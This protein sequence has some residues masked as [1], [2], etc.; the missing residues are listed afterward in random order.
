MYKFII[1]IL[2]LALACLSMHGEQNKYEDLL[3]KCSDWESDRI[4]TLADSLYLKGN[5]SEEEALVLYM[6]YAQRKTEDTS[7]DEIGNRVRAN[8]RAGNIHYGKGN[9]SNALK[10]YISGMKLSESTAHRPYIANLYNNI[11]NIYNMFQDYEKGKSMYVTG[12]KEARRAGDKATEYKLLQ[13]LVGVSIN[14]NDVKTARG[15]YEQSKSVKHEVTDESSYMDRYTLALIL[16]YEGKL[17]E[18]IEHF[19]DLARYSDAKGLN[20]RYACSAYGEIGRIYD[21]MER[22]DSAM[23][24]LSRCK[25]VAQANGILYQYTET[26]KMLYSLYD[27]FGDRQKAAELKDRYLELKDSIYN[28]R[29]FDM[30]KNQQF[31]YEMEKTEREISELNERQARD[32][33]LISRQR[34]VLWSVVG[35]IMLA[36]LLLHYFYRQKKKLSENYRNLYDIHQRMIA[37]HRDYTDRYMSVSRENEALREQ[38]M[39][40]S[41]TTDDGDV[42]GGGSDG[43]PSGLR[44]EENTYGADTKYER[45]GLSTAQ[46]DRLVGAVTEVMETQM[47]FCSPDFSLNSLASQVNSNTKYVSQVINDV[48]K[49]NFSTFV[50]EYRVNLACVRLADTAGYGQYSI[51]G[52]GDSVGFKSSATFSAVFKKMTGITPSVYQKLTREKQSNAIKQG[53]KTG[54]TS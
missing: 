1:M 47:P 44:P 29:Q 7:A 45:S 43:Q 54:K 22:T 17:R 46:R 30:A 38:I 8:M 23:Y 15:Y 6:L 2:T 25:D 26:V 42:V 33:M 40:L 5:G 11:G 53:N 14:L 3:Q 4:I 49:K 35:A 20:A 41:G 9:Y 32:A 10:Y 13:N 51:N 31:L 52:I 48:F 36:A 24:Y 28:Q 12:L 50:N 27:R 16:R 21:M 34:I 39:R 19:K 37:D 18:S